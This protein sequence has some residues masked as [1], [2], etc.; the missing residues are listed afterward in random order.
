MKKILVS[1][2]ILLPLVLQAQTQV[3]YDDFS[4]ESK[5]FTTA[6]NKEYTSTTSDGYFKYKIIEEGA[7]WFYHQFEVD[8]DTENYTVEATMEAKSGASDM[9][10]GL[11]IGMFDDNSN[12][13]I[14]L[15]DR[16]G[17]FTV[18]HYYGKE[19]HI[20]AEKQTHSAIKL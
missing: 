3:G 4:S 7:Y 2:S 16:S 12:Y 5:Y 14:F 17:K 9:Q 1:L 20:R 13:V 10:Y 19:Y 18:N 11:T 15:I 6:T 8:G